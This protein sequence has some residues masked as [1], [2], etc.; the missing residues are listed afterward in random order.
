MK[1]GRRLIKAIGS[2]ETVR[3][4]LCWLGAQYI[5]FVCTTTRWRRFGDDV[6]Q[7]FWD[8]GAPFI[9]AFWHQRILLMHHIWRSAKPISM[10][11]SRHRDGRIIARTVAHLGVGAIAGSSGKGGAGALR[12][13]VRTLKRGAYIGITPDGPRGPRMRAAMGIV[14]TARLSGAPILPAVYAVRR[15]KVVASWDRFIIALPFTRGVLMWGDPIIVPAGADR[16]Q[17]ERLRLKLEESLNALTA[18]ADRLCGH[19]PILPEGDL[20]DEGGRP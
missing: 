7:P 15:R 2:R 18:E 14:D 17:R 9:V 12:E 16:D 5:R 1:I 19:A 8:S 20:R 4:V 11:I 13:M 6:A 3:G 10:L